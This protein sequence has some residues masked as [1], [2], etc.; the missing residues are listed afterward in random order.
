MDYL[1][2][3]LGA[4]IGLLVFSLIVL[5]ISVTIYVLN[6]FGT[7]RLAKRRG[8]RYAWLSW[9]PVG[10]EYILG[11][12]SDD[13]AS[14]EPPY[15]RRSWWMTYPILSGVYLLFAI[16]GSVLALLAVPEYIV[17]IQDAAAY[18]TEEILDAV[19]SIFSTGGIGMLIVS[20]FANLLSIAVAVIGSILLYRIYK[21]YM[22]NAAL[23]F[24]ICGGIFGLHW[25]FVFI[26]RNR[27][28]LYPYYPQDG[29]GPPVYSTI[30]PR[31]TYS[32]QQT[33]DGRER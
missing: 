8:M 9:L 12:M 6:A 24:A 5:G 29:Y 33:P 1:S 3:L 4:V 15:L 28:P 18:G 7:Y 13:I 21:R 10:N 32:N 14:E 22:P 19:F 26:I 27:Q 11:K 23:P 17:R 2:F 30:P 20:Q 25:I 31:E 16:T